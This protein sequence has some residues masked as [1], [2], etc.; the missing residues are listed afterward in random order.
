MPCHLQSQDDPHS[1]ASSR[2]NNARGSIKGTSQQPLLAARSLETCVF[3][4]APCAGTQEF[5]QWG[6]RGCRY[7]LG[8]LGTAIHMQKWRDG[9]FEGTR[10]WYTLS[11]QWTEAGALQC[12]HPW[13][14]TIVVH[15]YSHSSLAAPTSLRWRAACSCRSCALLIYRERRDMHGNLHPP[16]LV[17]RSLYSNRCELLISLVPGMG[18]GG[19]KGTLLEGSTCLPPSLDLLAFL[20]PPPLHP[21]LGFLGTINHFHRYLHLGRGAVLQE[22]KLQ[23]QLSSF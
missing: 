9:P 22:P 7:W 1:L 13:S 14:S 12:A 11:V 23:H 16:T 10:A 4:L 2:K 15:I 6:K 19:S 20:V 3:S 8:S 18:V 17:L 5:H 21:L